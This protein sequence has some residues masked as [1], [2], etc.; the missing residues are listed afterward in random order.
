[1]YKGG[2]VW[3]E[4]PGY[5]GVYSVSSYGRIRRDREYKNTYRGRLLKPNFN[6]GG[7]LKVDLKEGDIH[8]IDSML[9]DGMSQVDIAKIYNID[10]SSISN[11]KRRKNWSHVKKISNKNNIEQNCLVLALKQKERDYSCLLQ[12]ESQG[13]LLPL[14]N[15]VKL[16]KN[17]GISLNGIYI[18]DDI[19]L[20]G[21]FH[22]NINN[23]CEIDK[24]EACDKA[25]VGSGI[26]TAIAAVGVGT[27][28]LQGRASRKA[29]KAQGE[30]IGNLQY[31][32]DPD[33]RET[34]DFLKDYGIDLLKG[35]IPDYYKGI[36]ETGGQQLE[37]LIAM[38]NR[39]ITQGATDALA[40]TGRLRGGALPAAVAQPIADNS[41]KL[42]YADLQRML[43]GKQY[44][45]NQGVGITEGVRGAAQ[46][47]GGRQNE[48]NAIKTGALV[49]LEGQK[50]VQKSKEIGSYGAA[51][52]DLVGT[53]GLLFGKGGLFSGKPATTTDDSTEANR[54]RGTSILGSIDVGDPNKWAKYTRG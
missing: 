39:D 7:Y 49:N 50:G 22:A 1:M 2:E 21:S 54:A 34:Q 15:A 8:D 44:L 41:T 32:E 5:E 10:T 42:R 9:E 47:E 46:T 33:Y 52:T 31:Y 19:G 20:D 27:A 13:N 26:A 51:L 17:N 45:M 4:I 37:D 40:K 48:F 12:L 28:A 18:A 11:I 16:L 38:T 24:F 53:E 35:D 25:L 6:K 43:Q 36:G 29:S 23:G 3:K 30:L 14:N